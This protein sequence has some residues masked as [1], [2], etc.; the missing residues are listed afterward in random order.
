MRFAGIPV[1]YY[2]TTTLFVDDSIDF[3]TNFSLQLNHL[4]A[5]KLFSRPGE[6]L[7][8]IKQSDPS[9]HVSQRSVD[10]AAE[11]GGNPITNHTVTLNLAGIQNE[12][13]N[14]KRF[15][16]IAV[17]VVDYDMPGI[18]GLEFCR[19]LADS[20][21]RKIL[22]TGKADEKIAVKAFNEG[23]IDHFIQKNN[24]DV[25]NLVNDNV[26]RL[27]TLYFEEMSGRMHAILT[28][29]SL[30]FVNDPVF[31][32]FFKNLCQQHNIVEYYLT[33]ITGSFLLL[34]KDA[35][36]SLLVVK[37]Y[38][39]LNIHYEFAADNGAPE[40]VL[41]EIRSGNKIPYAWQADD[42]FKM[43]AE[44]EWLQQLFP[45]EEIKGKD[46]YYY[47][48]VEALSTFPVDSKRIYS[49]NQY[50]T[51]LKSSDA[52]SMTAKV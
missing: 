42:Y 1:Y 11:V 25:V 36:P 47:S 20:P 23:I 34:N 16:E 50:L 30:S 48:Y 3:L 28:Q 5:T 45:A 38:E 43:Q 19:K 10:I 40:I 15:S 22:L 9:S 33:E 27:Q 32:D 2:P 21:I 7:A 6:A 29:N 14:P 44:E 46:T 31:C 4:L 39:D 35:E 18:N 13:Y 41:E 24:K 8:Y 12:I 17:V 26:L 49:Y 37:C 51:Q 52:N